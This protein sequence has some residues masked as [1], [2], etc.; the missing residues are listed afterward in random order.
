VPPP[1]GQQQFGG[2]GSM[3]SPAVDEAKK[4]A[5]NS[6]IAGLVGLICAGFILGV[7]AIKWGTSARSSLKA[8]G[9]S[10]GQGLATAGIVLG[11]VDIIGWVIFLVTNIAGR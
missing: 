7:L 8:A 6:L 9:V 4:T 10:D 1:Y 5:R 11:V 2:A 3:F